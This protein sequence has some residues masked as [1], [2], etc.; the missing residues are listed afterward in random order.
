[1]ASNYGRNF[2][3]RR[4]D[5]SLAI[6]EGRFKTKAGAPGTLLLGSAVEIDSAVPGFLKQCAAAPAAVTG[7]RGILVQEEDHLDSVFNGSMNGHDSIDLGISK[8]DQ[9]ATFWSGPGLKVWFKNT[10]AYNRG[11]RSRGAVTLLSGTLA[12]GA[13]LG[14]DGSKWVV[15]DGSVTPIWMYITQFAAGYAEA[16]LDF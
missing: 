3:F 15:T 1:M 13:G 4:S 7:L 6:R 10:P 12:L 9:P 11:T 14:W 2:G 8:P 16:V 5:E